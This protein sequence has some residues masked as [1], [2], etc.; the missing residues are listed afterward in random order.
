MWREPR[1]AGWRGHMQKAREI[2]YFSTK[3]FFGSRAVLFSFI[4]FLVVVV[5]LGGQHSESREQY[6]WTGEEGGVVVVAFT[7]LTL[8][9][10]LSLLSLSLLSLSSSSSSFVV[11]ESLQVKDSEIDFVFF[12][13]CLFCLHIT[14]H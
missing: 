7:A 14:H 13:V 6:W 11:L 5:I 10:S 4:L 1:A 8:L 12:C 2:D 9:L 3:R